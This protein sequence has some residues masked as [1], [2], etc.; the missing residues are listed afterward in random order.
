[1]E[2]LVGQ[3]FLILGPHFYFAQGPQI[4]GDG[5]VAN[6]LFFFLSLEILYQ[7]KAEI[8]HQRRQE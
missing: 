4:F 7:I 8:K 2:T 1:V 6:Y 3:H 5:P